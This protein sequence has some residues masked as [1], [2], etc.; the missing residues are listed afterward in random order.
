MAQ[1]DKAQ[2]APPEDKPVLS[3]G[4]GAE[5]AQ[6][7]DDRPAA[8]PKLVT[9]EYMGRK[10]QLPEDAAAEWQEREKLL[11][12]QGHEIGELRKW[13]QGVEQTVQPRPERPADDLETTWFENPRKAFD[14]IKQEVRQ[15]ITEEYRVDQAR[16]TF[17]DGF[18]RENP[19]LRDDRWVA[20]AV[21]Q[22]HMDSLGA[23]PVAKARESLADLT[24]KKILG[25][26]R[27]VKTTD[28]D[29]RSHALLEPASGD[30]LPAP[31]RTEDEGP[32]SLSESL[33]IRRAQRL[34]GAKGA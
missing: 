3:G 4:P 32:K 22:E 17:W 28:T 33:A 1:D 26:T 29:T 16:R 15:E 18:D 25:L 7:Q 11:S 14:R 23:L 20:E 21:L 6:Q 19:D 12:K 9:V 34:K 30:R 10:V 27:K 24:R 2:G 8:A 5:P 13:R 31:A